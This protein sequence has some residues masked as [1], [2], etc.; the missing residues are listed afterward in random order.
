MQQDGVGEE[1]EKNVE[2]KDPKLFFD[3]NE[4]VCSI[5]YDQNKDQI[6][7]RISEQLSQQKETFQ[8]ILDK[9]SDHAATL[10]RGLNQETM[11]SLSNLIEVFFK[12]EGSTLALDSQRLEQENIRL[13]VDEL[14]DAISGKET[15]EECKV[16]E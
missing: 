3:L 12:H 9:I 13:K 11:E 15:Q 8:T 14:L 1:V 7:V 16:S 10:K 2:K 5:I 6:F 4:T